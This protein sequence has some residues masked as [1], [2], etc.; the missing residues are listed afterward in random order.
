MLTWLSFAIALFKL[1]NA[2]IGWFQQRELI[3]EGYQ[4]AIAEQ[5]TKTL[6]M[7]TRGKAILEKINAMDEKTVDDGLRGLEPPVG[8]VRTP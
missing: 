5:A 7:T 2:I 8:S 6:G 4:Q 1:A 3:N